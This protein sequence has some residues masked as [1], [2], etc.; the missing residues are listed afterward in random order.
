M[1]VMILV[2][3][4]AMA[5]S[6]GG[7]ARSG[8]R[9]LPNLLLLLI[10]VSIPFPT[11][12]AWQNDARNYLDDDI[13]DD[14]VDYRDMMN[15]DMGS[16]TMKRDTVIDGSPGEESSSCPPCVCPTEDDRGRRRGQT[17]APLTPPTVSDDK[18]VDGRETMS[19]ASSGT[20]SSSSSSST[21][22]DTCRAESEMSLVCVSTLRKL[23]RFIVDASGALTEVREE[24]EEAEED[25]EFHALFRLPVEHLKVLRRVVRDKDGTGACG[26]VVWA[27]QHLSASMIKVKRQYGDAHVFEREPEQAFVFM[28][29]LRGNAHLLLWG[30]SIVA[31]FFGKGF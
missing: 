16:K 15:Y 1:Y 18:D 21:S 8:K 2:P 4:L 28:D 3:R 24:D 17:D 23:M 25:V 26:D 12:D 5:G 10:F 6:G 14:W 30:V 27:M 11:I 20:S 31:G 29:D 13:G 9:C 7:G 19:T 22:N